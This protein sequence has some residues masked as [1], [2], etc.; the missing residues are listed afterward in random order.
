M[1]RVV[2]DYEIA[3]NSADHLNPTG[4]RQD[5]SFNERFWYKLKNSLLIFHY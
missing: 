3:D 1:F 5:N 4:T 2:S